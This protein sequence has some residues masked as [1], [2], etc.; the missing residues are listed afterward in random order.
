MSLNCREQKCTCDFKI[1]LT[2]SSGYAPPFSYKH[3]A[4]KCYSS[5]SISF[6]SPSVPLPTR[7]TE[8]PE[9]TRQAAATEYRAKRILTSWGIFSKC[10]KMQN[11]RKLATLTITQCRWEGTLDSAPSYKKGQLLQ[12]LSYILVVQKHSP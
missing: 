3:S 11:Q 8:L 9:A 1:F 5:H 2:V 12:D 10:Q 4:G 7:F 6:L